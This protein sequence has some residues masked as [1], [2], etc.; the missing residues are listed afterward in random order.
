MNLRLWHRTN[1]CV[2]MPPLCFFLSFF[3]LLLLFSSICS[4]RFLFSF[5]L[6]SSPFSFPAHF[7]FFSSNFCHTLCLALSLKG[8][9]GRPP[10]LKIAPVWYHGM[11]WVRYAYRT[12]CTVLL[13]RT[14]LSW[15]KLPQMGR[16]LS[17]SHLVD[18]V[19]WNWNGRQNSLA[20]SR[21]YKLLQYISIDRTLSR[22]S[23]T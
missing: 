1:L 11:H 6:F 3:F 5:P 23:S 14:L 15:W 10:P 4:F 20:C 9:G 18:V 13:I 2:I 7:Y 8:E 19:A 16:D 21:I 17:K 22:V 12:Q